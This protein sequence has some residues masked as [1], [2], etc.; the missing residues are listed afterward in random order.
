MGRIAPGT[1]ILEAFPIN[2][3]EADKGA[4]QGGEKYQQAFYV[5]EELAQA[6]STT[7]V[8]MLVAQAVAELHLGRLEEAQAALDQA[9]QKDAGYAEAL[10]NKLVLAAISGKDATEETKYVIGH[11]SGTCHSRRANKMPG[12]WRRPR[13]NILSSWTWRRR[14]RS[15]TRPRPSTAPRYRLELAKDGRA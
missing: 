1:K 6:P 14:A 13:R 2:T 5:F 15:S 11:W 9:L 12:H 10:A 3:T 4:V 7:S 8:N